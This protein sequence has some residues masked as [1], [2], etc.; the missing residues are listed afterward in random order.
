MSR[1]I[2]NHVLP[3]TRP[4]RASDED[5]LRAVYLRSLRASSYRREQLDR[6]RI[7]AELIDTLQARQRT[8]TVRATSQAEEPAQRGVL[9]SHDIRRRGQVGRR[10][11]VWRV[12]VK[13]PKPHKRNSVKAALPAPSINGSVQPEISTA[14]PGVSPDPFVN[15]LLHQQLTSLTL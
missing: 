11:P 3:Y 10:K 4:V 6:Q 7:K 5:T 8:A 14:P 13:L 1:T 2:Y 9:D 15:W 12:A